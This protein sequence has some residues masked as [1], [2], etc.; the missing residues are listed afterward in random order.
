MSPRAE[1]I[2]DALMEL[3]PSRIKISATQIEALFPQGKDIT[4][5]SM[6]LLCSL[7]STGL[8]QVSLSNEQPERAERITV[9]CNNTRVPERTIE[10]A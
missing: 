10:C 9:P 5:R 2:T 1:A 6:H 3:A 8:L 4:V 7:S